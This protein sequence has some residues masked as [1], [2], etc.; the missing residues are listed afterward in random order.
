MSAAVT[1]VATVGCWL[2]AVNLHIAVLVVVLVVVLLVVL[3][4]VLVA[5]L[6][7][8]GRAYRQIY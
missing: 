8:V 6:L 2:V 7:L 4:L 3:L 1:T 5:L